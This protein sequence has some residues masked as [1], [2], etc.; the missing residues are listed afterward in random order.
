M[1]LEVAMRIRDVMLLVMGAGVIIALALLF[2]G[3]G[4]LP[5]DQPS[6][7][8]MKAA[9]ERQRQSASPSARTERTDETTGPKKPRRRVAPVRYVGEPETEDQ[10]EVRKTLPTPAGAGPTVSGAEKTVLEDRL[11]KANRLYDL[12]DYQSAYDQA[13]DI[14][15][16]QPLSLPMRRVAV[17]SAC[18]LGRQA[19]ARQHFE[20]LPPRHRRNVQRQCKRQGVELVESD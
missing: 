4:D 20:G 2:T 15:G 12:R 6:D 16:E 3:S 14:L 13:T 10:S 5:S 19:D 7:E 8:A 9:R 1:F 18:M 17:L 11:Y